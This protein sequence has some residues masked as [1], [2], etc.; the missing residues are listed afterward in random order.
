MFASMLCLFLDCNVLI[1][2]FVWWI[3]FYSHHALCTDIAEPGF[4]YPISFYWHRKSRNTKTFG[5]LIPETLSLYNVYLTVL[6]R[7]YSFTICFK[8]TPAFSMSLFKTTHSWR[9]KNLYSVWTDNFSLFQ[10]CFWIYIEEQSCLYLWK[11]TTTFWK[12]DTTMFFIK[13]CFYEINNTYS[14]W[15]H[16]FEQYSF[17]HNF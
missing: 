4:C 11:D 1:L 5:I 16:T 15:K 3:T 2:H 9:Y 10:I 12:S 14:T 13:L 17:S 7:R 8:N 6:T